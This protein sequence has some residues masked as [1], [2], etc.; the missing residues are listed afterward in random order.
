MLLISARRLVMLYIW[1]K[2]HEII[3]NSIKSYRADTISIRK[4][5]KGNNS[6]K[7]V[8]GVTIVYLCT[9]SGHALYFYQVLW[10]YLKL[11]QSF[12]ADTILILKI[13]KGNNSAKNVGGVTVF[14]LCTLSGHALYFYQVSWNYLKRYQS[15]RA[16]T[17]S[18]L[19]ITKEN[20]SAKNVGGVTVVHLCT[21][22]CHALYF[23][24]VSWHYLKRYQSY[25]ADTISILKITKENHSAK[26]V[27]G[28]TVVHLCTLSGHALYFYQVLWHYLKR[29]QSYRADTISI[30]RITKENQSAKNVGG[31]NV[32]YLCTSSGHALYF[33]QVLWHYLKRYQS[34]RADTISILKITKGNNS[35]KNIG[36]VTVVYLFTS[37][38]HALYFYLVLWHYLKRYQSYRADTISI[39][40]ITKG[41]NSAKNVGGVT[42]LIS[43][44]RLVMLYI[45]AKF[46]E[47][48]SNG[49]KVIERTRFLYW[50]FEREI[51]P[52]M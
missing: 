34:Y 15:Y 46:H 6:A 42:V 28:V 47:I 8:S 16:D 12:R 29:Y 14:N 19:K 9:S 39:L 5:T 22:S 27:G 1:A 4:I 3:L 49:I 21:L 24:Q 13:T 35:A 25:R 31:V 10:N 2:F 26:N 30:L 23:Y 18:I 20:H 36:G 7:N 50:K 11:Y 17:I 33:Y 43:A 44:R 38:G 52:Q 37:S 40:K 41:N 48:I 45:C 51:I 32:V